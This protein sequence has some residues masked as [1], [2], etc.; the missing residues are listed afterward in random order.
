MIDFSW[1]WLWFVT[2]AIAALLFWLE[3][4]ANNDNCAA[5]GASYSDLVKKYEVVKDLGSRNPFRQ[6]LNEVVLR[7]ATSG[8]AIDDI[9]EKHGLTLEDNQDFCCYRHAGQGTRMSVMILCTKCGNKR[10][11]KAT[12]CSYDCTD[13]NEP[14][15]PGS[16]YE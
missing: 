8:I 1:A 7:C 13:S 15:Q 2:A 14:G 12:D 11:P 3:R 10:C 6:A 9:M 5:F 16:R 4:R